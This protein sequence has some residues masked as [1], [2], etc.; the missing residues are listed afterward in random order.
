MKKRL[1]GVLVLDT[2]GQGSDLIVRTD[3]RAYVTEG[4]ESAAYEVVKEKPGW[5]ST[6]N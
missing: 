4:E 1:K 2:Y 5:V 3:G 6:K